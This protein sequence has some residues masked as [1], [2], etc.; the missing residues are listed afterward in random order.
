VPIDASVD[1]TDARNPIRY[2]T[3]IADQAQGIF[4]VI[5]QDGSF[6][7]QM[8]RENSSTV[9]DSNVLDSQPMSLLVLGFLS[10]PSSRCNLWI[11]ECHSLLTPFPRSVSPTSEGVPC[12]PNR[13]GLG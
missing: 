9:L 8:L 3:P 7:D 4:P 2:W 12:A 6:L 11:S 13:C 10:I 5:P 1:V